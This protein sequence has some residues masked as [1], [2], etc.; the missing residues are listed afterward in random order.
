MV[1]NVLFF[2]QNRWAF[3]NIHHGLCKSLY[4]HGIIANV[5]DFTVSYSKEEFRL[6]DKTYDVFVTNP[7]AVN[8]LHNDY[9]ISYEKI[10]AVAHGEW[11][12]HLAQQTAGNDVF[13]KVRN[14]GVVSNFLKDSSAKIGLPR[15]PEVIPFG[16][17]TSHLRMKF[18]PQLKTVG[19]AGAFSTKNFAGVE[20]KR[21]HLVQE[22][23]QKAKLNFKPHE[24]YNWL[25]MPGYYSEIDALM[26]SSIEE[27]AS[28]PLLEAAS[29]GR[30][31]LSTPV[32]YFLDY[33]NGIELPMD[34]VEYVNVAT[35]QL[36]KYKED[37]HAYVM[38][39]LEIKEFAFLN[40]D[41]IYFID[42]W[43]DFFNAK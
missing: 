12:L 5:I 3:G 13:V 32:G 39:C 22:A 15:V 41:W 19:Y 18:A 4:E 33:K 1:K 31:I 42:K 16:V 6:L 8:I 36:I 20:I 38:K 26:V 23:V 29:A 25:C 27:G 10:C 35:E 9:G 17:H 37:P 7:E 24:F 11:D 40:F 43:V 14:F 21:G 30:L 2:T 28:L 34:E